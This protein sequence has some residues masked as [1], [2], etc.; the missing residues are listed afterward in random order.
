V[1]DVAFGKVDALVAALGTDFEVDV[2]MLRDAVLHGRSANLF[3]LPLALK[4]D[5]FGHAHGPYN[6]AEFVRVVHLKAVFAS[7]HRIPGVR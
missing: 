7:P 6:E 4:I 2:A 3:Y 1:I 5:F